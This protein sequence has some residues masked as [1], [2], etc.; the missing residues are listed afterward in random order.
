VPV[1]LILAEWDA[2]TP[3]Y[4]AQALFGRLTNAAL[5]RHV[6]IGEGTHAVLL[7]RNRMQLFREVQLF[8]EEPR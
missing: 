7:E 1:Q 6:V 2:G 5:K 8:L 3:L 4:M